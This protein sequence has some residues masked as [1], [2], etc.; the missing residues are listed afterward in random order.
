VK[1]TG[2]M[3]ALA[4]ALVFSPFLV[5]GA[6]A[7]E[8]TLIYA[9]ISDGWLKSYED[10]FSWVW[11]DTEALS[12][13]NMSE[14][15][16]VG[17]ECTPYGGYILYRTYLHFPDT[18][19]LPDD[20]TIVSATLHL[21]GYINITTGPWGSYNLTIQSGQPTFPHMPLTK[22][23]Y[24]QGY[25]SDNGGTYN[26][27]NFVVEGWNDVPLN[28]LG[29][30]WINKIG[31]TKFC[32]RTD[33]DIDAVEVPSTYYVQYYSAESTLK[34]PYLEVAYQQQSGGI[35]VPKGEGPTTAVEVPNLPWYAKQILQWILDFLGQR[36][37]RV[38]LGVAAF[39][40]I[41]LV[42]LRWEKVKKH[43]KL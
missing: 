9:S 17:Q 37:V 14:N 31:E 3:L 2:F 19:L 26:T 25:Y 12:L 4:L 27:W 32:L 13:Y 38:V 15:F 5:T 7:S 29:K 1:V 6:N 24:W 40:G 34:R 42:V 21:F 41:G 36:H 8:T 28:T 10:D 43:A 11:N 22:Y 23:D 20:A 16:W 33:K 39:M 35:Y 18:S 30:S